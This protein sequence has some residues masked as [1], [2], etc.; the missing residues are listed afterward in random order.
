SQTSSS[1][2]SWR[3]CSSTRRR[4][5]CASRG[6]NGGTQR[7]IRAINDRRITCANKDERAFRGVR[8]SPILVACG[9]PRR[10]AHESQRTKSSCVLDR[11][12][13]RGPCDHRLFR[14]HHPCDRR[15][16]VLGRHS[17]LHRARRRRIDEG[18]L[19]STRR[20]AQAGRRALGRI[21]GL[22]RRR[23]RAVRF[24]VVALFALLAGPVWADGW[25]RHADD[26]LGYVVEL[27]SDYVPAGGGSAP[28]KLVFRSPDG[29]ETLTLSGGTVLPG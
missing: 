3:R 6:G 12:R 15:L 16:C 11:R 19:N 21:E 14:T 25:A 23:K 24:A 8:S 27:P 22:R 18:D 17:C 2:A 7:P 5:Y 1:R 29:E 28:D 9:S 13:S 26:A 4:K 20:G 10:L